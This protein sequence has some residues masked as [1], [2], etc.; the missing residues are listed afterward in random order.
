MATV[1]VPIDVLGGRPDSNSTPELVYITGS[2]FPVDGYAFSAGGTEALYIKL[3]AELYGNA[4]DWTLDLLW[5]SRSGSTTGNVQWVAALAAMTPGDS[6][7][8]E[9]KAFATSQ[10]ATITVNATAKGLTLTSIAITNLD[11]VNAGDTV[12]LKITRGTDTMV[13]NATLVRGSASYSDGNTGTAGSGDVVGPAS[14]TATAFMRANGTTGKLLQNSVV[15]CD[16]SGN[17]TGVG[18]IN[19]AANH[20]TLVSNGTTMTVRRSEIVRKTADQTVAL[21]TVA[22][23]T[24]LA[25]TSLKAATAYFFRFTLFFSAG[26]TTTGLKF[27]INCSSAPTSIKYGANVPRTAQAADW[28]A[29]AANATAITVTDSTTTTNIAFIEGCVLTNAATDLN[30]RIAADVAANL[31]VSLNSFGELQQIG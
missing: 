24:D 19:A 29:A 23:C 31:T 20:D 26:V 7:S 15:L 9:T 21:T 18:T 17:L 4:G 28:Q 2:N 11:S 30:L 16:S 13:G 12:W 8:I 10:N 14:A 25:F 6:Q 3:G 22:N 1:A 5:Y 27:D